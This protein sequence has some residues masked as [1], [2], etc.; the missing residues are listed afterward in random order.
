MVQNPIRSVLVVGGGSAGWMAAAALASAL[1]E[2]VS[3]ELVESDE[4]G[5]VGVGEATIPPIKIFNRQIGL[6]EPEFVRATGGAFKLGIEFVNW[7]RHGHRFAHPF[8]STGYDFD[9]VPFDQHWIKLMLEGKAPRLEEL[10]LTW[11]AASHGRFARIPRVPR[12]ARAPK[13]PR[14]DYAYHFDAGLYA[15]HLRRHSE[16]L[17]V[18]RHE[19]KIVDVKRAGRN[20]LVKSVKLA[21]GRELEADLFI[22]CSGFRALLIEGAMKSKFEDWSHW[23]PCDRALAVPTERSESGIAPFTRSTAHEAGWQWRISSATAARTSRWRGRPA[24]RPE[25]SALAGGGSL[26]GSQDAVLVGVHPVEIGERLG[27]VF[28]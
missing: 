20:G 7:G 12:N 10:T 4:I 16:A 18:T 21:D 15:A 23:L 25:R 19:G 28:G 22:D 9:F 2:G 27:L 5:T 11:A 26:L 1:R 6:N 8:G 24:P 14:F 17:G 3:I 13:R